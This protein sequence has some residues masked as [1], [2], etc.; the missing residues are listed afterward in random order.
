MKTTFAYLAV[1]L[2]AF[3]CTTAQ[4]PPKPQSEFKNLQVLPPDIPR[5]QLIATMRSFTRSLG[6]KCNE[7]HVVTATSPEEQLDFPSDAREEKRI[8]RV[9]IQMTQ[10]LNGA[11][12][13]RVEKAEGEHH[14]AA[15]P[16][17]APDGPKLSCWTC[18]RGKT[19]PEATAPPAT[20]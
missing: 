4:Q 7:C 14:E 6:V 15:A 13:E 10:Q 5:D 16:D 3:G 9:M 8:A 19:E 2:L 17:E 12:M 20:R 1:M 11:W 18:H